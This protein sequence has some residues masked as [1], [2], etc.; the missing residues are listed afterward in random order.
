MSDTG[1]PCKWIP[2]CRIGSDTLS[3]W[4]HLIP[5]GSIRS[6]QRQSDM[7]GTGE[8]EPHRDRSLCHQSSQ[9]C[10]SAS[11]WTP[12]PPSCNLAVKQLGSFSRLSSK[13]YCH[14]QADCRGQQLRSAGKT[15]GTPHFCSVAQGCHQLRRGWVGRRCGKLG[16]GTLSRKPR[17]R[18]N[19]Y[20]L[21]VEDW[22]VS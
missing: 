3:S 17:Y 14:T 11:H 22:S 8:R 20:D 15:S 10:Q 19:R 12:R 16:G 18:H 9:R 4:R 1:N 6:C 13:G 2:G 5:I 7:K 21:I